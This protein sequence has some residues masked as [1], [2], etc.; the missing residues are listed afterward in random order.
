MSILGDTFTWIKGLFSPSK[1]KN[2]KIADIVPDSG[3]VS[4][5]RCVV[6]RKLKAPRYP[7]TVPDWDSDDEFY[8]MPEEATVQPGLFPKNMSTPRRARISEQNITHPS[9]R[10]RREK[11][12]AKFN[13]KNDW[14]DY[15]DHFSAV[16]E[17]NAWTYHD[18]GLQLAI[19]L[20]DEAR[21]VL[22]SLSTTQKHDYDCLVDA[23][24]RRFSPD[25][26]ESQYSLQLMN[27]SCQQ[28]ED[29]TSYGHT[30][31]R[32]AIKAYPGQNVDE[33]WLVDMYI[34]GLPSQEMKRHVYLS[35]P[36]NLS[37]AINSAVTYEAFDRP[38]NDKSDRFRKPKVPIAPIQSDS[39]K[40]KKHANTEV[41][42]PSNCDQ[43]TDMLTQ[44]SRAVTDLGKN[45]SNLQGHSANQ[46][47]RRNFDIECFKCHEKG[48]YA[49]SCP[50]NSNQNRGRNTQRNNS[51]SVPSHLN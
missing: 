44:L 38:I 46:S 40:D 5:E 23:L 16:A 20:T 30:I 27:H 12:P 33:K 47:N 1:V 34:R 29:V 10:N 36:L 6:P 41:S 22:G 28:N 45:M 35:K 50:T 18:M 8:L 4:E 43:L 39:V 24:T 51:S 48:H 37:E 11:E 32:L 2:V 31:R 7:T 14:R 25:G 17:W 3:I 49:R 26:R 15:L 9:T 19:S 21:E 13:G 42:I